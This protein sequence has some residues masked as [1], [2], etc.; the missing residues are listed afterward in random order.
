MRK[1]PIRRILRRPIL[2]FSPP[3]TMWL[4]ILLVSTCAWLSHSDA[5]V[6]EQNPA[7]RSHAQPLA[8]NTAL[9]DQLETGACRFYSL[10]FDAQ[11]VAR[12]VV[13]QKGV[14]AVVRI[15]W[16]DGSLYREV[17]NPNGV[18]GP[19]TV[20]IL[21]QTK[22]VFQIEVKAG[23]AVPGGG[24][25]LRV[26]GPRILSPNDEKRVEAESVFAEAQQLRRERKHQSAIQKYDVALT[27]WRQ[28]GDK[29]EEGYSLTNEGRVYR[30][31]GEA[32]SAL[33]RLAE[34]LL[35]LQEA[36][37]S[38]GQAFTL[39]EIGT[40]HINFGDAQDAIAAYE[41]ALKLRLEIPDRYGQAQLYNNLGLAYSYIGYQPQ[42]A[43]N[44]EKALS[45]WRELHSVDDEMNT[46]VNAAKAHA[47]MGDLNVASSQYDTVLR[48]CDQYLNSTNVVLKR[49]AIRLKPYALNGLGLVYDTWVDAD[50]ARAK[51]K[52]ALELF[53]NNEDEK[54]EADVLDNLGLLHAFL[55]D[56]PQALD[57][58]NSA[59]VI[60][61][62]R[63]E[64]KGWGVTLSNIGLT[65]T[66]LGEHKTALQKLELALPLCQRARDKRFEA[67][68]LVRMGMA[69]VAMKDTGRALESYKRALE[70]QQDPALAD[71]RGQAITL[72]K[73]GEA[74]ALSG[75][76][77]Q[78]LEAYGNAVQRWIAVGDDQGRALSLYG[79]ARIERNRHNLANARDRIDEAIKLVEKLRNR[80]TA[81]QLQMIYF[82]G[83][84]DLYA[85]A[86]DVRMQLYELTKSSAD[87]EA[88][89]SLSEQSRARNLIDL[90]AAA[91]VDLSKSMSSEEAEKNIKLQQQINELTQTHLRL[92]NVKAKVDAAVVFETLKSRIQEQDDLLTSV[93]RRGSASGNQS[94]RPL[95]PPQIQQLL[96]DKT[97]VL[98]FSLGEEHSHLWTIT[99]SNIKYYGLPA[100]VEIQKAANKLSQVLIAYEQKQR[101]NESD[102]ERTRRLRLKPDYYLASALDLSRMVLG[103]VWPQLGDKRLVIVADGALQYIPFEVLPSP[104]SSLNGGSIPPLVAKNEIVYQP[105]ASALGLLRGVARPNLSKTVAVFADPVFSDDDDRVQPAQK[106]QS[107]K[108]VNRSREKLTSSLRDVGDDD[109]TLSKLAYSLKEANGITALA[110]RG[111]WMKKLGFDANRAAAT[112]PSLKQFSIVH[113]ATHG[114]MDDKQPELSGI[115]LSMVNK[116]GQDQDGY[117][118]L[119][120]IYYL[121]LPI[122]LVVVSACR[123]GIGKQIP[124]EG[125]IALTRGFMHAGAEG[126]VVSLWD[127]D[128]EATAEFMTRFYEQMLGK[129]KLS[130]AAALRQAKSEMQVHANE[131]WRAPYYWAGFVLQGDWK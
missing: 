87:L 30:M 34:A 77:V 26:D 73:M 83:K 62:R 118:T 12:I 99:Q 75:E 76:P 22:S 51:Y 49:S 47:E 116:R 91:H 2:L 94:A 96:D 119:H 121:D 32:S 48:Y 64:L 45:I 21:A 103:K 74:L 126:V 33:D 17:D 13:E 120:D 18:Y 117:L 19:E 125:L 85:L 131:R 14:D 122:R 11:Q 56:A 15:Y 28:L 41:K 90:L 35:R 107:G 95:T 46:L 112:S 50:E 81:R 70:I 97:M 3:R 93:A 89:L 20:T 54:A 55:G 29:R 6:Q 38:S 36:D 7:P 86:I 113:F 71:Q 43:E 109:F 80:V 114:I 23:V 79:I 129:N 42:A 8:P 127:V 61:E 108:V 101:P 9:K 104:D 115:V 82:G 5:A 52:E 78:A 72:D 105:S 60:R 1:S 24:Y 68:T 130:P 84:Q 10:Q 92:L 100:G 39:N 27:L 123:T 31:L 53:H 4:A 124:G 44:H 58:F 63:K 16:P 66:L 128:D 110:P 102:A 25:E 88:A 40:V 57:Y 98:E 65:Y 69:Y 59:L 67:Y 111:S 106:P 37:D